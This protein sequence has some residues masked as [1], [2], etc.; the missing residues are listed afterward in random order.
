M[1]YVA[2]VLLLLTQGCALALPAIGAVGGVGS[3]AFNKHEHERHET[4]LSDLAR[5]VEWL[6]SIIERGSWRAWECDG[7][8]RGV[9]PSEC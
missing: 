7:P 2:V 1:K 6:E 9:L 5:R 3:F 8:R 4:D